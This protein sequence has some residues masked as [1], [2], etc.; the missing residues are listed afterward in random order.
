M[1]HG[2]LIVDSKPES[3]DK[4][5]AHL[6]WYKQTHVPEVLAVE[7]FTSARLLESLER[8]S[9]VAIF[10]LDADVDVAKGNLRAAQK[11]GRWPGHSTCNSTRS[12]RSGTS[13]RSP[14]RAERCASRT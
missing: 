2:V 5:D 10:E 6:E 3:P 11:S 12:R 1:T 13:W 9:L 8:D 4:F 14:T 7:G